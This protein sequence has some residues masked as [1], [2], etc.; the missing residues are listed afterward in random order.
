MTQSRPPT[1]SAIPRHTS[2]PLFT[3]TGLKL[4]VFGLNVTSAGAV[5]ASPDR[6]EINW[7]QN[8]RLVRLAEDAGFEAAIP[9]SRWRGFEGQ[10]NPWGTSF[11]PYTW[12]SA[13][14]ALT[15]RISIFTTSHCLTVSPVFAAKQIAT[16]D[17]VSR[18]RI[19]LN[20]VAGWFA[21]E[22]RMFNVETLDHEAR[23]G[24]SEEWLDI[25]L[26][27]WSEDSDDFDY[28][29]HWLT[30]E[31]GYSHPKPS[32]T[33]HPPL[34][35]A[36]FSARGHQLAARYADIAFV[37]ALDPAGVAKKVREIR[38]LAAGFERELSVW[39]SASVVCADTDR[40]AA[41]LLR[42]YSEVDADE[43]AVRNAIEWT[44][45]GAQMPPEQHAQLASAVAA[46]MAGYPLVGS[47]ETIG[48]QLSDLSAAGIDGVALTWMNYENG[49]PRFIADVLPIL[50]REGVR[51]SIAGQ[52]DQS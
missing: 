39:V 9:F 6:H 50:E 2:G 3:D 48:R 14:A 22:L 32:Q 44:M 28:R 26:R 41:Q 17:A 34:M 31:G 12:A 52:L 21:K 24:Y 42:Q 29:G 19:G 30:V 13:L 10:T 7:D 43:T 5:T 36:A 4:G 46:T 20:V 49:L 1:E 11:E 23:Y 38:E 33:P 47:P 51:R 35:N 15:S 45:G 27:L 16:I 25:L 8:V 37:S 40:E 18:G